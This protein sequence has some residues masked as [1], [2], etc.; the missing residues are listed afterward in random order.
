MLYILYQHK[1]I[2]MVNF[3]L[4]MYKKKHTDGNSPITYIYVS[5]GNSPWVSQ[6]A[7]RLWSRGRPPL[8]QTIFSRMFT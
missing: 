3:M 4:C 2:K 7:A 8:F 6:M 1:R 5:G